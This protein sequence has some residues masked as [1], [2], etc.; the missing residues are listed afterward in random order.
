[1]LASETGVLDAP[2]ED[3]VQKGRLQPG[4]LFLVDVEQGRVIEDGE[5]KHEVAGQKPYGHWYRTRSLPLDDL[6]EVAPRE[7]AAEPLLTRQRLFGY[8][9]EDLRVTLAQMG[10][11]SAAEPIGSMGNDFALA[12]LS[13]RGRCSTPTSSSSSRRS[14]TLRSTRSARSS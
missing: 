12:V 14:R 13:D 6:D 3:I 2:P 10:G 9:Q 7:V 11:A 4:K 1:M 5:V 8:S